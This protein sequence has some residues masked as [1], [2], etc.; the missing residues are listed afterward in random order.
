MQQ[1]VFQEFLEELKS[2]AID[3]E[4][5]KKQ[6]AVST[7]SLEKDHSDAQ[8]ASTARGVPDEELP[9]GQKQ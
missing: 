2:E 5:A 8:R 9:L 1:M 4:F 7:T 3:V 6:I